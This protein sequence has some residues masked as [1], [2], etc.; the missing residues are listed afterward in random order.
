MDDKNIIKANK[1]IQEVL[2]KYGLKTSLEL[3]FPIYR[4]LPDEVQLALKI[5]GKHG[6]K[7]I[8]TLEKKQ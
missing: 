2:K 6:M 7:I 5:L 1:E 8:Y 3:S 4:I